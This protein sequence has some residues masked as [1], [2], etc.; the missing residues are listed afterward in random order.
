MRLLLGWLLCCAFGCTSVGAANRS[1]DDEA[2]LQS[3]GLAAFDVALPFRAADARMVAPIEAQ[4]PEPQAVARQVIYSAALRVVVV[5]AADALRSVR[6]FAEQADGYLQESD[7][8]SITVRVPAAQ[9][10]A[11]LERVEALGE[12]VE[13]SVKA[14]DVTEQ[15]LDLNIRLDNARRA[16]ERLLEHLAKSEKME[17]TLKIEAELTRVTGELELLEGK[18]RYLESQIAMST[19]RVELNTN[20]PRGDGAA[21]GLGLPFEW[22]ARLGDG[23]VAGSVESLPRKPRFLSSGPRF[24]PPAEFIRYYSSGEL[25]EAMNA[26]GVRIKVQE[27]DNYD[28]GA[29]A[30]W[31]KLARKSLVEAR[32]LAVTSEEDLGEERVLLTG[33]RE[34]GGLANGYMLVLARTK[35]SVY[36]FE[37]WGPRES[38]EPQLKALLASAKSL[39]R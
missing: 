26:D 30:F 21:D 36:S 22:L 7:A 31:K 33:T 15:M 32:A 5:S 28:Q 6:A 29:L 19:I 17:D 14:S 3:A 11:V 38:F 16:R 8:R 25:V 23:L 1:A 39:K 4:A 24:D 13:R 12:V 10:D 9:F 20:Q 27:H 34:V 18:L 35:S 2:A 37:A